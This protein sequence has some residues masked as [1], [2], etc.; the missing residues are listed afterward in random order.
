MALNALLA[1]TEFSQRCCVTD[2]V[3]SGPV[4]SVISA[5]CDVSERGVCPPP[6]PSPSPHHYFLLCSSPDS[7]PNIL[8]RFCTLW[9]LLGFPNSPVLKL[10]SHFRSDFL[11]WFVRNW[12]CEHNRRREQS[13]LG[14]TG[15]G[16]G[17]EREGPTFRS[18]FL[19]KLL[20]PLFCYP[21]KRS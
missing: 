19:W 4:F 3:P 14:A 11:S 10:Q 7:C 8:D 5:Q 12:N 6:T 18:T 16:G 9:L 1:F 13:A 20:H 17:S 21:E 2:R 15:L